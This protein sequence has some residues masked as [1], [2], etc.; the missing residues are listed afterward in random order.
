[1]KT[2]CLALLLLIST[3]P[4]AVSQADLPTDSLKRV[5]SQTHQ[6]TSRVLLLAQITGPYRFFDPDSSM[7]LAQEAM[8]LAVRLNF[9]KGKA[10]CLFIYVENL[11][12]RGDFPQD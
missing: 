12:F 9:P 1:M 8:P 7:F 10:R 11:R 3:L 4:V 5:L 2:S 6:D